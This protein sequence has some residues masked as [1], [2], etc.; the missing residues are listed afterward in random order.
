MNNKTRKRFRLAGYDYS[1]NGAYFITIVTKN[2]IPFF[3]EIRNKEMLLSHIG[4]FV[5]RN[6]LIIQEKLEAIKVDEYV[7]MPDHLHLIISINKTQGGSCLEARTRPDSHRPGIRPL[8]K[9]SVSSFINHLK[10]KIKRWCN[11]NGFKDFE[12]HTR[13]HDRII[14]DEI[15]YFY[16]TRLYP[17]QYQQLEE[18]EVNF[19]PQGTKLPNMQI[20]LQFDGLIAFAPSLVFD[21]IKED[22][23]GGLA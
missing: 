5:E 15:S 1:Q 12:W 9:E 10:G 22:F 18:W 2:R 16:I 6:F 20:R 17:K 4:D 19:V 13:F 3:G 14:R 7:I 21:N 23:G 11:E 8:Q